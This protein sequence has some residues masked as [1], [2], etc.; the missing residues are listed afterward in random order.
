[1]DTVHEC[2]SECCLWCLVLE[3]Q[4]AAGLGFLHVAKKIK[5]FV[6]AYCEPQHANYLL[7]GVELRFQYILGKK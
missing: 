2:L 6:T 4:T 1:M 5:D 7:S 3:R